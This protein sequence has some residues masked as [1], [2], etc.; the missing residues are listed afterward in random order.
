MNK[1][2]IVLFWGFFYFLWI[3]GESVANH[4]K[5]IS[6]FF[7]ALTLSLNAQLASS[8]VVIECI[9]KETRIMR[10]FDYQC[11]KISLADKLLNKKGNTNRKA[12]NEYKFLIKKIRTQQ[13]PLT[14]VVSLNSKLRSTNFHI[15][16]CNPNNT[17]YSLDDVECTWWVN[18]FLSR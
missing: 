18:L 13:T 5:Y 8:R 17:N 6:S 14:F 3:D 7:S 12:T 16:T 15:S 2:I 4:F 10:V 11:L 1:P 9:P